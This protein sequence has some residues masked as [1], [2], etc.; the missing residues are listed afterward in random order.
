MSQDF[1]RRFKGVEIEVLANVG[2]GPFGILIS[3]GTTTGVPGPDDTIED[4]VTLIKVVELDAAEQ[5][6]MLPIP[7]LTLL[8]PPE[9]MITGE[10]TTLET[11]TGGTDLEA[12]G[13][14]IVCEDAVRFK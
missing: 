9:L 11:V 14:D 4:P 6:A 8:G 3:G 1:W 10:E 2:V 7:L 13:S 5:L 12:A